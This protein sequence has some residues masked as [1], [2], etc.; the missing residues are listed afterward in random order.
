MRA[1]HANKLLSLVVL[2][3]LGAAAAVV[4]RANAETI[5]P[6]GVDEFQTP[7]NATS[8][9]PWNLPAG[10]FTNAS[11]SGSNALSTTV[12]YRGGD[13]VPGYSAD[14]VISR[15]SDVSVPGS[16]GL[17]VVGLRFVSTSS[18]RVT[19]QDGTTRFYQIRVKESSTTPSG[20]EMRL[21]ADNTFDNDLSINR[22]YTCTSPGQ[23][24][25]VFESAAVGWDPIHLTGDGT[26]ELTGARLAA[27]SR[28]VR[29]RP[30]TEQGLLEQHG[31]VPPSP[32]PS[33]SP[34]PTKTSIGIGLNK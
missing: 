8:F 17:T 3:I 24:T 27:A 12:Y 14:T 25:K 15:D 33:P 34:S 11:G 23:P 30:R 18:L 2:L 28:N 31:L 9:E 13:A 5:V 32:S 19:F 29:I 1:F 6:A 4:W 26:W 10:F 20:G 22:E 7:P 21:Y 16:T